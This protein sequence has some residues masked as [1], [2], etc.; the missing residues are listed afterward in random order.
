MSLGLRDPYERRRKQRR[1]AV[2]RLFIF[3]IAFGISLWIAYGAGRQVGQAQIDALQHQL[4]ENRVSQ[5]ALQAENG[6]L[7]AAASNAQKAE[8]E[9]RRRYEE[10]VPKGN[11]AELLKL[12][13]QRLEEGVD[14]A[15][16][17]FVI[18]AVE[19]ERDCRGEPVT[20]R[21]LVRTPLHRGGNDM[22]SFAD[23]LFTVTASGPTAV[24]ADGNP[25]AW[26]DPAATLRLTVTKLGG[27]VSQFEGELPLH[28]SVV[29][30]GNEH[31]FAAQQGENRG[32]LRVTHDL[33]A[34]P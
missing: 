3:L 4:E 15:R 13:R 22:A 9:W 20:R 28:F 32:F 33:C 17:S 7:A 26:F 16:L 10:E 27:E 1:W 6:R 34:F 25:E 5:E 18:S 29:H 30:D 11:L 12:A 24:N 23:G 2:I 31:L 19:R 14:P 21:F 8:A